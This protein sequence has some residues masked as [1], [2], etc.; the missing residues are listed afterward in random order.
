MLWVLTPG[1]LFVCRGRTGVHSPQRLP[2]H[3]AAAEHL[4]ALRD[5]RVRRLPGCGCTDFH[6][7]YGAQ[8]GLGGKEQDGATPLG[9]AM[10]LG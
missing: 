1:C 8:T 6:C 10:F 4:P 5:R 9:K 7:R 3:R 2:E